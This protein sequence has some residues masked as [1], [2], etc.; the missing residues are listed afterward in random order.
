MIMAILLLLI[1]TSICFSMARTTSLRQS[2]FENRLWKLQANLLA[3]SALEQAAQQLRNQS[4]SFEEVWEVTFN[5]ES[6][7]AQMTAQPVNSNQ[8]EVT[9]VAIYPSG[10]PQR[11][12]TTVHAMVDVSDLSGNES[13]E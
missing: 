13:A 6:G 8:Y 10:V 5:N 7:E 11:A 1:S 12:Q 3:D 9:V 2:R 4:D